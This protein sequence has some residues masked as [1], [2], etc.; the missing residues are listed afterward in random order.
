MARQ[1][2]EPEQIA[3]ALMVYPY[4]GIYNE[5][6]N[7]WAKRVV[8]ESTLQRGSRYDGTDTT[9]GSAPPSASRV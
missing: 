1:Q 4:G 5:I 8:L 2:S 6:A 3:C 9:C 7:E